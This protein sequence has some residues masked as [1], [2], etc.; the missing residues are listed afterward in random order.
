MT[1]KQKQTSTVNSR[2]TGSGLTQLQLEGHNNSK[3]KILA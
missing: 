1:N 2:L 3:I